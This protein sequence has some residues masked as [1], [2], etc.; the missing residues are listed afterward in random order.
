MNGRP[1]KRTL[2]GF[3]GLAQ[4][5]TYMRTEG[6]SEGWLVVFETRPHD[7]RQELPATMLT[8]DGIVHVVVIDVN[9]LAPSRR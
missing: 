2:R 9:P 1:I 7:K 5:Q 8:K 4:L 3:T 6:R